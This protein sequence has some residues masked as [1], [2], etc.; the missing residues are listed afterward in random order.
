MTIRYGGSGKDPND[1][2]QFN[3]FGSIIMLYTRLF[4]FASAPVRTSYEILTHVGISADALDK[5]KW[6]GKVTIP[7]AALRTP[8]TSGS[9][10]RNTEETLYI[11]RILGTFTLDIALW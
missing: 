10:L 4:Y 2:I 7:S 1:S 3:D 9:Y 5:V 8:L 11:V 6:I